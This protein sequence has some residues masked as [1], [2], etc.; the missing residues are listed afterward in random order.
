MCPE[1]SCWTALGFS[2][3]LLKNGGR[4]RSVGDSWVLFFIFTTLQFPEGPQSQGDIK[5]GYTFSFQALKEKSSITDNY[6][7]SSIHVSPCKSG[8]KSSKLPPLK[9]IGLFS[10]PPAPNS[11]TQSKTISV[12]Q[13]NLSVY[14]SVLNIR[15]F[16][17]SFLFTAVKFCLGLFISFIFSQVSFTPNTSTPNW[18][19]QKEKGK[20]ETDIGL[21]YV[22][23]YYY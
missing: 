18:M 22:S 14:L 7:W 1:S 19:I 23:R 9:G 21:P 17:W 5:Q 4:G 3:P 6:L 2:F 8:S 15:I 10:N 16:C 13:T 12:Y 11:W 20:T